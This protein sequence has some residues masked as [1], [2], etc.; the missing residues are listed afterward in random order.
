LQQY[1]SFL[2]RLAVVRCTVVVAAT[3]SIRV[4][5][6]Q[7]SVAKCDGGRHQVRFSILL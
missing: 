7:R 6:V 3:L 4:P 2:A 5:G 1:L